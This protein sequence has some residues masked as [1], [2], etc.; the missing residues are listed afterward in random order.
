MYAY[1]YIY[2]Y[3]LLY[4]IT[5]H[6]LL[7]THAVYIYVCNVYVVRLEEVQNRKREKNETTKLQYQQTP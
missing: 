4:F 1:L 6:T 7:Y 3:F 2:I 5:F